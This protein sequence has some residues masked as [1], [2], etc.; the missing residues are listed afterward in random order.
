MPCSGSRSR[1]P[2]AKP[3][4]SACPPVIPIAWPAGKIHGPSISPLSTDFI[5][6]TSTQSLE[7]TSRTVVKP[8]SSVTRALC[9]PCSA[10]S[11]SVSCTGRLTQSPSIA[12]VKCVCMSIRPGTSVRSPR[13]ITCAPSGTG[14]PLL[15]T[16]VI[17]RPVTTI[18]GCATSL[19]ARTSSICAARRTIGAGAGAAGTGAAGFCAAH[20]QS[21]K[22]RNGMAACYAPP[23]LSSWRSSPGIRLRAAQSP[24]VPRPSS[25]CCPDC[26]R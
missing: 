25:P 11:A 21:R 14:S 5:S 24:R 13:S 6:E 12:S 1:M 7:P 19:P 9:A 20:A 4:V 8:A 18:C 10:A 17:A 22:K 23:Q 15:P 2:G 16:D 26:R 3:V